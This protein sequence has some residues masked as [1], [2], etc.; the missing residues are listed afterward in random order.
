VSGGEFQEI[1]EGA[2]GK[3]CVSGQAILS[4]TS[5]DDPAT[6]R[7][8]EQAS[9]K[10]KLNPAQPRR[11]GRVALRARSGGVTFYSVHLE[12]GGDEALRANQLRDIVFDTGGRDGAILVG[13]D[14]NNEGVRD[15]NMFDALLSASFV[16]SMARHAPRPRRPIDWIYTRHLAGTSAPVLSD[17]SDHDPVVFKMTVQRR[18]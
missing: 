1:G 4:R 8:G 11:G 16:N 9:W 6:F 17:A 10:W 12:S 15:S 5:I 18:F 3:A 13:G 7:F 14:F 2:R